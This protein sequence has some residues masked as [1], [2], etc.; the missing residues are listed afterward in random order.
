MRV[1]ICRQASGGAGNDAKPVGAP[2]APIP[3]EAEVCT[4]RLEP[5]KHYWALIDIFDW[6]LCFDWKYSGLW[7]VSM[8]YFAKILITNIYIICIIL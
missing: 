5:C 1:W 6:T 4:V 2:T 8:L 3:E 7:E